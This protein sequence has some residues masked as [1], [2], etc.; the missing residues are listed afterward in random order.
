[1]PLSSTYFIRVFFVRFHRTDTLKMTCGATGG[2]LLRECLK[3]RDASTL[4]IWNILP[5]VGR[6]SK[7]RNGLVVGLPKASA[8]SASEQSPSRC[9]SAK[10]WLLCCW[11]TKKTTSGSVVGSVAAETTETTRC[12]CSSCSATKQPPTGSCS[13]STERGS[14][15]RAEGGPTRRSSAKG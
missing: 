2:L 1:M 7:S 5:N 4:T 9:A 3:W 15:L 14:I 13:R 10:S 8:R 6:S 12:S 11:L